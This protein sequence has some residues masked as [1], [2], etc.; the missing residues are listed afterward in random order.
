MGVLK[1]GVS[2]DSVCLLLDLRDWLHDP[3]TI[4]QRAREN[5]TF[6]VDDY[7]GDYWCLACSSRDLRE[8]RGSEGHPR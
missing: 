2:E 7:P 5:R 3:V 8:T 1:V 6:L 4:P